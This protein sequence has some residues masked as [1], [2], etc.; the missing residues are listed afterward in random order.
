[1]NVPVNNTLPSPN[2]MFTVL[3][4]SISCGWKFVADLPRKNGFPKIDFL[5]ATLQAD[6]LIV[7]C[8]DYYVDG[9]D[10]SFLTT[11]IVHIGLFQ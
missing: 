4:K 10:E 5:V 7:C 6:S 1:M 9:D 2:Y 11:D 8:G 3:M